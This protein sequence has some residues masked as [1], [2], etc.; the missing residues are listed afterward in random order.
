MKFRASEYLETP[1]GNSIVWRY[2]NTWKFERFLSDGALF[3]PNANKLSDQYEVSLP[4]SAELRKRKEL[5]LQGFK[6]RELE[7]EMASFYWTTNPMK[8]LVLINC[9]SIFPH[10]SYAL[11]KIYLG[12]EK[13]GVAIKT[14]VSKLKK[15]VE[16]GNDIY[17][18]DFFLGKVKYKKHLNNDELSRLSIIT[19][20]KPF[21]D[22]EK[23]IRLFIL[24]YPLSEGG[25]IPPYDLSVG[26]T[27]K[28]EPSQLVQELYISPFADDGYTQKI[29]ELVKNSN[30]KNVVLKKSE[31]LDQ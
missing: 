27:V 28:V 24:N 31:I 4:K 5:Q 14:T 13:N 29:H 10:E 8:E 6:G 22:F 17:P 3:F 15:A 19:T 9:W 30:L 23:E 12:G 11:W 1:H 18:E 26:R 2:T 7:E 20:K 16:N 21:Y 25:T